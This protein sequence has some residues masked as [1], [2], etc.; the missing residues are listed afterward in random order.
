M[1]S[2]PKYQ[3]EK[4]LLREVARDNLS[5]Y[6]QLFDQYFVDLCN[7]LMIYLH[8]KSFAEEIALEVFA[9][10]WEKRASI[11]IHSSLKAYLFTSAK[12]RA[13]S[14]Y[15]REKQALFSQLDVESDQLLPDTSS[16][17]YLENQELKQI[18]EDAIA[19]L[20]EKSRQIYR[21]AWEDDLSHKEIAEKLGITPKTVENHVGIALRKLKTSLAPYYRQIFNLLF[22]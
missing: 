17:F 12:N 14:F 10:V 11:G 6:R 18:I 21:M 13:I 19:A 3:D 7:F 4:F 9:A 8:N 2:R 5:A 16:Q 22:I 1:N 20:P 15:R